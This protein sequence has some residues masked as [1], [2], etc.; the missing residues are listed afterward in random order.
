MACWLSLLPDGVALLS[1]HVQPNAR[2]TE[3][4]GLQGDAVKLRLAAPLPS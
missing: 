4:V 1:L 2:R 3:F